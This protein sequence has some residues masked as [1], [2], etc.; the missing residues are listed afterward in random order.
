MNGNLH[1]VLQVGA[2]VVVVVTAE[3]R[4]QVDGLQSPQF[5]ITWFPKH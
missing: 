1:G 3:E 2:G 5:P 4:S